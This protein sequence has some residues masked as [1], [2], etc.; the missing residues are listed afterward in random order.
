MSGHVVAR[1][2]A[3]P[4]A[5]AENSSSNSMKSPAS[6]VG[7]GSQLLLTSQVMRM[8]EVECA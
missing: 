7:N 1:P 5:F 3:E 2:T 8:R 4:V 6:G